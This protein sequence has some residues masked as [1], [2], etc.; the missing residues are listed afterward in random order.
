MLALNLWSARSDCRL[1][2]SKKGRILGYHN[3]LFLEE[4]LKVKADQVQ[5]RCGE[6]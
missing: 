5:S 4:K 2:S 1:A 3:S 6:V